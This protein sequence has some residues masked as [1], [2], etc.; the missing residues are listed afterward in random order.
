MGTKH[1]LLVEGHD[2]Q[3]VIRELLKKS[4]IKCVIPERRNNHDPDS[5]EAIHLRQK[6]GFEHL[7]KRLPADLF[8]SELERLGIVVD[9]DIDVAARWQSLRHILQQEGSQDV[10]P[11]PDPAGTVC[12]IERPDRTVTVGVW[13]MP[14]NSLP[15]MLEDFMAFLIPDGDTL[16]AHVDTCFE[17]IPTGTLS[18]RYNYNKGRIHAWLAL[19]EE[20]G[21]P[22]GQA[23]TA[24]YLDAKK[25][26]AQNF[27]AWIRR[28]YKV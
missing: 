21:K 8:E 12:T 4:H 18:P 2:D 28:L 6:D 16:L 3:Y 11:H 14:D 24:H 9:A 17:Q 7:R 10:P 5:E 23:I 1:V 20:P 25:P 13:L 19:Q 26:Y 15:G 22:L 27:V